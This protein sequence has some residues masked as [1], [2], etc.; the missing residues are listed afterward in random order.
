ME[1]PIYKALAKLYDN[2][3]NVGLNNLCV[4]NSKRYLWLCH[5]DIQD[6]SLVEDHTEEEQME[7]MDFIEEVF[8]RKIIF[9]TF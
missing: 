6:P 4:L 9:Q 8:E 3:N 1:L 2:Y 7:E 5:G